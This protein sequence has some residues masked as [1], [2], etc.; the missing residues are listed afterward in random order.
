MLFI[1]SL[2][3]LFIPSFLCAQSVEVH[4]INIGHGD[5]TL[6]IVRDI[7]ALKATL[8]AKGVGLAPN[9][10]DYLDS[11]LARDVVLD[12]TVSKAI[13]IDFGD[14]EKQGKKIID[15][16]EK[17][18]LPKGSKLDAFIVTHNHKDHYGGFK[19]VVSLGKYK[20][21]VYYRGERKLPGG[22]AFSSGFKNICSTYGLT[23]RIADVSSTQIDLG[24]VSGQQS[25]LTAVSSDG[26][27]L[28]SKVAGNQ[29]L[30]NNQNDYG[31]SWV[32]QYGAFRYFIGGDI[33]GSDISAYK[34]VETPL[35]DSLVK[36]DK[37]SFTE[38]NTTTPLRKGHICAFKVD[39]HGSRNSSNPHFLYN[40]SP[41]VAFVSCGASHDHPHKETIEIFSNR[42][43]PNPRDTTTRT[44]S[45]RNWFLTSLLS[46]FTDSRASIG[47]TGN[48]GII[49][50]NI[51]LIVDDNNIATQS[52]YKVQWDA[53]KD[54]S[55]VTSSTAGSRTK[56]MRTPNAAG[57][58][59]Y[60][61]HKST[62]VAPFYFTQ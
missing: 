30:T 45:L 55:M 13:L 59:T 12:G 33:S 3:L 17:L 21:D 58:K 25:Y 39:H 47:T 51:V 8:T 46:G 11:A 32:I 56:V 14:G 50:G 9:P 41:L 6:I 15:R 61:C 28:K 4:T 62:G 18:G 42:L 26:Y 43:Q 34:N 52:K 60:E 31:C 35:V 16:M 48:P 38:F 2:F 10:I 49:G 19:A 37:A 24:I 1:R 20:G 54:V 27:V 29:I 5:A 57:S 23:V 22:S 40:I 7:T 36:Y 53:E 44:N